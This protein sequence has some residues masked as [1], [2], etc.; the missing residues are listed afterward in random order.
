VLFAWGVRQT[1]IVY[2]IENCKNCAALKNYLLK[3]GA[4][5]D[6]RDM[7]A[8]ESAAE[9][10]SNGVF[11]LSA[12]V[13]QVGDK[14]FDIRDIF[15]DMRNPMKISDDINNAVKNHLDA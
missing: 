7:T 10:M 9:L 14:F 1:I 8:S 5:F 3:L 15:P 6:E 11:T 2:T 12:P 13:L 4:K